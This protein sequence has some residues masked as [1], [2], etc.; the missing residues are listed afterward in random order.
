MWI[1]PVA[2][3]VIAV[4]IAGGTLVLDHHIDWQD[5][6]LPLFKGKFDAAF[7]MLSVIATS[8]TTLS[9]LIFTIIVVAIQLASSQY[10][11]RTLSTLL[12]DR[13]SHITIAVFVGT[14]TYTLMILWGIRFTET[15]DGQQVTGISL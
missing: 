11:P 3:A 8:V 6:P 5:P 4:I 12:Q 2:G 1:A 7:N 9:A 10:S 14:F 13:P 15:V